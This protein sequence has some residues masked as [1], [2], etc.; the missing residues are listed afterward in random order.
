MGAFS[1]PIDKMRLILAAL[2]LIVAITSCQA[3]SQGFAKAEAAAAVPAAVER[4]TPSERRGQEEDRTGRRGRRYR[5][6]S[7]RCGNSGGNNNGGN[8]SQLIEDLDNV[9]NL[10]NNLVGANG[11]LTNGPFGNLLAGL[12]RRK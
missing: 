8:L 5:G 7:Y 9:V 6:R 4:L 12:G 11:L 3:Q 1:L 2:V 10:T